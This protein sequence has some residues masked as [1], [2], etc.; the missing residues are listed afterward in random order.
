MKP[1]RLLNS[2]K[3]KVRLASRAA[4]RNYFSQMFADGHH[5]IWLNDTNKYRKSAVQTYANDFSANPKSINDA[6]LIAYIAASGPT[7]AIDGWSYLARSTDAL[8]RGDSCAAL[9]LAYYAELRAAMSILACEG[10]GVFKNIHPLI[11][12]SGTT[13]NFIRRTGQWNQGTKKYNP[14]QAGTH[15][16]VWPLLSH[17]GS[18][19]RASELIDSLILLEGVNLSNWLD[20]LGI[21][22]RIK[23]ISKGWFNSW[24]I[25]L[26]TLSTDHESRNMVSYRPSELRHPPTPEASL[27]IDFVS[28]LWTLFQ[29]GVGGRFPN[30]ER[31]LLRK[32]IRESGVAVDASK[33]QEKLGMSI[34]MSNHWQTFLNSNND[35]MP[36]HFADQISDVDQ[37]ECSMQVISRAALL[38]F[39]ATGS[40]RQH[41][42]QA[43]YTKTTLEFF[44]KRLCN[45]R[46]IGPDLA[47]PNDPIDF[48]I[49]IETSIEDAKNWPQ[50]MVAGTSLGEWR[51]D[52]SSVISQLG[53]F[54]LAGVW[55]LT[56]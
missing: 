12:P 47:I 28:S 15:I 11:D 25:D 24:G 19:K 17:W 42:I 23:A 53:S 45:A 46:Y 4:V 1:S 48:W 26:S 34:P 6:D 21:P 50:Y 10:V 20:A 33:L 54:E 3:K 30:L 14:K 7:H 31:E 51:K 52:Q 44:W 27:A 40:T 8:L 41:L 49:D 18:L 36:L 55:G 43:G 5:N 37:T 29:P 16:A 35:A 22:S 2:D 32:I 9:H 56:S 13:T 39:V 38:L